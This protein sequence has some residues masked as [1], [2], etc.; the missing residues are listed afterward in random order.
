[1]VLENYFGEIPESEINIDED[2]KCARLK[3]E[4][5]YDDPAIKK[6]EQAVRQNSRVRYSVV[7]VDV[8]YGKQDECDLSF[9]MIKSKSLYKLLYPCKEAFIFCV[10]LGNENERMLNRLSNLSPAEHFLF[11][12][13]SSAF[14]DSACSNVEEKIK[15]ERQLT[16]R[17][18][19][20]YGD[21][22]LEI[23]PQILSLLNAEKLLG[24]TLGKNLL[25]SP[26]KTITAIAGVK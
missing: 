13:I 6:A 16:F 20:G 10:T 1:M 4:K 19:I 22:P 9:G 12:A 11:D 26:N 15:G 8:C 25:M 23:Q 17:F 2:E 24:I 21:L 14:V 18:G 3:V 5:G 7:R